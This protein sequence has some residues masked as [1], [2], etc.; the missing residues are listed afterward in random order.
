MTQPEIQVISSL[1]VQRQNGDVLLVRYDPEDER[2]WLP[3]DDLEPYEHPDDAAKRFLARDAPGLEHD[4]PDM[5]FVESFRGRRGWHVIFH[6]GTRARGDAGGERETAWFSP[7]E[8]PR[9]FH[10][11]WERNVIRRAAELTGV[12]GE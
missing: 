1:V 9:T 3:G 8:L 4:E 7:D 6:Y 12:A 10:G 2:W 5:L 11:S